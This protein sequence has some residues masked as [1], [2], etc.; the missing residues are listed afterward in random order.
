MSEHLAPSAQWGEAAGPGAPRP[1]TDAGGGKRGGEG[2]SASDR[3]RGG[4]DQLDEDQLDDGQ[5]A[6]QREVEEELTPERAL[7][8]TVEEGQRRT[9][10]AL[11]PMIATGIVGGIDVGT[12]VF[13]MLVVE[14][15]TGSSLLGGLAF[16]I[17]FV[18]LLLA[19][20]ELFTENFLVP[21]VAMAARRSTVLDVLRLWGVAAAANLVGGWVL[22]L[23]VITGFPSLQHKAVE[24]GTLYA[25]LGY[26]WRSFALGLLGGLVITLMTWM[27]HSTDNL[28][29]KLVPAVTTAFLLGAAHLN[30][31]IVASLV[32]FGA[33]QTGHAPF[34][35]LR[36]FTELLFAAAAN[37]VGGVGLVTVLRVLQVPR[38]LATERG[39]SR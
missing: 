35:Y 27:Q 1:G 39:L 3:Q 23:L 7:Q 4:E 24:S 34:G 15:A 37:I 14:A 12:G 28:V 6:G 16:S 36:W 29:G 30:H 19:R 11:V 20:S 10:R 22:M 8:R 2:E 38:R 32:M 9:D 5:L 26:G 25:H 33:L 17:G 13:A 21:V 31:A 18:A